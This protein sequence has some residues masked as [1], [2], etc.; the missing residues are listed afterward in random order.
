MVN[1]LVFLGAVDHITLRGACETKEQVSFN[2]YTC[3]HT[4]THSHTH[5]NTQVTLS[6]K[7]KRLSL[8]PRNSRIYSFSQSYRFIQMRG[9]KLK[10]FAEMAVLKHH[11]TKSLHQGTFTY[12]N[13]ATSDPTVQK[14]SPELRR[15]LKMRGEDDEGSKGV[16]SSR[17]TVMGDGREG[18][19]STDTSVMND[20]RE[21]AESQSQIASGPS[22]NGLNGALS[23][24]PSSRFE[25]QSNRFGV[26]VYKRPTE[27]SV[28][29]PTADE[30]K[31]RSASTASTLGSGVSHKMKKKKS[32]ELIVEDCEAVV[33]HIELE[34]Y[35]GPVATGDTMALVNDTMA[36]VID[37]Q[38]KLKK[39]K[40][41]RK[42]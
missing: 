10:G 29:P 21:G 3:T 37:E 22:T 27:S 24:N 19:E 28:D 11:L 30:V 1:Q 12:T 5:T 4:H 26:V 42:Q 14:Y 33:D 32:V 6:A 18:A 40:L 7:L 34:T 17:T 23:Q 38:P 9:P 35:D 2:P 31:H 8:K 41:S 20:G 25:K 16:E 39:P 13:D 15:L 36:I